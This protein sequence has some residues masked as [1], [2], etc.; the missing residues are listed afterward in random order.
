[1]LGSGSPVHEHLAAVDTA[2]MSAAD[3]VKAMLAYAGQ[4]RFVFEP[5]RVESLVDEMT[6]L[7]STTISQDARLRVSSVPDLPAV[8]ADASQLRQVVMNLVIN[9]SDA[10]GGQ[11]GTI[12]V[13]TDLQ[14][15][16]PDKPPTTVDGDL[17]APGRYVCLE[18]K[19][20]GCGMSEETRSRLFEPFFTTK[21]KGRGLGMAAV[22]G[23]VHAHKGAITV[24]SAVGLGSVFRVFLPVSDKPALA[25]TATPTVRRVVPRPAARG[26]VLLVDDDEIARVFVHSCLKVSGFEALVAEDGQRAV[27]LFSQHADRVKIVLLDMSMP[28]LDGEATYRELRRIRPE[29]KVILCSGHPEERVLARFDGLAGF[30]E[31]PFGPEVLV[32]KIFEALETRHG[33]DPSLE[34]GPPN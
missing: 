28:G 34:D 30:L 20:D 1:K 7:F 12:T 25:A 5:C 31:K 14:T 27:D 16:T 29:V 10:L 9:A 32:Q 6:R 21:R 33:L 4:A 15:V 17:L 23:I 18:I 8:E 13:H 26:T 24:D 3:L 11:P 2:A 22:L 19:D